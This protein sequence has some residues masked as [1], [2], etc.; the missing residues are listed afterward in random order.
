MAMATFASLDEAAE[1]GRL[2]LERLEGASAA[3]ISR[4]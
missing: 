4:A 3:A 2:A 1:A